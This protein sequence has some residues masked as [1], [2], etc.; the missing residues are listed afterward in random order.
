[1]Q[2][3]VGNIFKM[4]MKSLKIPVPGKIKVKIEKHEVDYERI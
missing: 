2:C 1:M 3:I 4:P